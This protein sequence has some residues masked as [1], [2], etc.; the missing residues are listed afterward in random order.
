[1]SLIIRCCNHDPYPLSLT[2]TSPHHWLSEVIEKLLDRSITSTARPAAYNPVPLGWG[3][4]EK[5][6]H[7]DP[8]GDEFEAITALWMPIL[9]FGVVS[10]RVRSVS[11][12]GVYRVQF[13][14]VMTDGMGP[15]IGPASAL[16]LK[17]S[18]QVHMLAEK[19][20]NDLLLSQSV[21]R[22]MSFVSMI[23]VVHHTGVSLLLLWRLCH[24]IATVSQVDSQTPHRLSSSLCRKAR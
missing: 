17:F 7:L 2:P 14:K 3:G 15:S 12:I 20:P 8:F 23:E 6:L 10:S 24:S 9:N 4:P 16:A 19:V 18:E 1:M 13:N 22:S 5:T 21:A 11:D